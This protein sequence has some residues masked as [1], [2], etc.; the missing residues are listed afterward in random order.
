MLCPLS[1]SASKHLGGC[2]VLEVGSDRLLDAAWKFLELAIAPRPARN[3]LHPSRTFWVEMHQDRRFD[4]KALQ[5]IERLL[6]PFGPYKIGVPR[7]IRV[8]RVPRVPRVLR[9]LCV[10]HVLHVLRVL[11]VLHVLRVL[12]VLLILRVLRVLHVLR[13]LRVIRVPRVLR[14]LCVLCVHVLHVL[15]LLGGVQALMVCTFSGDIAIP[16]FE[17]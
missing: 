10:L 17:M 7:V 13:V 9:V 14:V 8:P 1:L 3:R 16:N 15:T 5:P 4:E 12:R 6:A 2:K 11:H